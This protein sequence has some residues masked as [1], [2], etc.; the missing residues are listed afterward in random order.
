MD[1]RQQERVLARH[2]TRIRETLQIQSI[3]AHLN[4]LELLTTDERDLLLNPLY[5][6]SYKKDCLVQWLP[7]KG[8][9][10]LHRFIVC[11]KR[12]SS[13]A[14]GHEELAKL[15][16]RREHTRVPVNVL[17]PIISS[18]L[19]IDFTEDNFERP[20]PINVWIIAR[21]SKTMSRY[22]CACMCVYMY[23]PY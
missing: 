6:P 23:I 21:L 8:R 10:A 13:D 14:L 15:L 12:S 4:E 19:D 1:Q 11:L 22:I 5:T 2:H 20:R 18:E 3:L 16:E 7:Q 9:N 17:R